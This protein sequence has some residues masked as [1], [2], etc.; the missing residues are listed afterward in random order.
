MGHLLLSVVVHVPDTVE[1][2]TGDVSSNQT[3]VT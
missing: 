1:V 2:E 3:R